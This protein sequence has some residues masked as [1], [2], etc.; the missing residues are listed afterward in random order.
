MPPRERESFLDLV[1]MNGK[2][3]EAAELK[4]GSRRGKVRRPAWIHP[5]VKTE[6]D[7]SQTSTDFDG[8]FTE[9]RSDNFYGKVVRGPRGF[10]LGRDLEDSQLF[11][12]S[13]SFYLRVPEH[14]GFSGSLSCDGP[15][16]LYL[17]ALLVEKGRFEGLF[18]MPDESPLDLEDL[19][20]ST[21]LEPDVQPRP[22]KWWL[23]VP[24]TVSIRAPDCKPLKI[25]FR[26]RDGLP[27]PQRLERAQ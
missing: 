16:A 10:A 11:E 12:S 18:K 26:L 6:E 17:R 14:G 15:E 13:R 1:D 7:G 19:F 9:S 23:D 4:S 5:R 2:P 27:K 20:V 22:S 24:V 25:E 21:P 8:G 3:F